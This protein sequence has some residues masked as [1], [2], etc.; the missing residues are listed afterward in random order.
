MAVAQKEAGWNDPPGLRAGQSVGRDI[1][2]KTE[3]LRR[4]LNVPLHTAG[5]RFPVAVAPFNESESAIR[6][7]VDV[8]HDFAFTKKF[9]ELHASGIQVPFNI[10]DQELVRIVDE[11]RAALSKLN[12]Y[13]FLNELMKEYNYSPDIVTKVRQLV[14]EYY[15]EQLALIDRNLELQ[16]IWARLQ[17]KGVPDTAE[18]LHLLYAV[19]SGEINI[20]ENV[21]WKPK[22]NDE[23]NSAAIKR[24]LFSV[25]KNV[26]PNKSAQGPGFF[27]DNF[28]GNSTENTAGV[29]P[30]DGSRTG[31]YAWPLATNF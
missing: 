26:F 17:V 13:T 3:K 30:L 9:Q 19:K 2:Q 23:D 7:K 5:G 15:E 10:P 1:L 11:K 8:M 20:P 22:L 6:N 12:F 27:K 4:D 14:P 25:K 28:T 16:R 18:E 24:G 31:Q 21:A 29:Y